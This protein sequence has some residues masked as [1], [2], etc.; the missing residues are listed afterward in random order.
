MTAP[1]ANDSNKNKINSKQN[2]ETIFIY[3]GNLNVIFEHIDIEEQ[4]ID[5]ARKLKEELTPRDAAVKVREK[6][7]TIKDVCKKNDDE[8]ITPLI[9]YISVDESIITKN[10][11]SEGYLDKV[12]YAHFHVEDEAAVE[13]LIPFYK[14]RKKGLPF[15]IASTP[16]AYGKDNLKCYSPI[17]VTIFRNG[18]FSIII[19]CGTRIVGLT[20]E[21]GGLIN[22]YEYLNSIQ[23]PEYL[24]TTSEIIYRLQNGE[25]HSDRKKFEDFLMREYSSSLKK[26]NIK[27]ECFIDNC[28]QL[29]C[30]DSQCFTPKYFMNFVHTAVISGLMPKLTTFFNELRLYGDP[31]LSSNAPLNDKRYFEQNRNFIFPADPDNF[32]EYK[33]NKQNYIEVNLHRPYIGTYTQIKKPLSDKKNTDWI[34]FAVAAAKT[35]PEYLDHKICPENHIKEQILKSNIFYPRDDFAHFSRRGFAIIKFIEDSIAEND[36][37]N[38]IFRTAVVETILVV[39]ETTLAA[40]VAA[41]KFEE[42]LDQV[43]HNFIKKTNENISNAS[44]SWRTLTK[45]DPLDVLNF[46]NQLNQLRRFLSINE[47]IINIKPNL[48]THSSVQVAIQIE[49]FNH[50]N[51]VISSAKQS[52]ESYTSLLSTS[53]QFWQ[54]SSVRL[55]KWSI[56]AAVA[57][58]GINIFVTIGMTLLEKNDDSCMFC[59]FG[60]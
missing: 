56:L 27:P 12:I 8:S 48:K 46:S 37:K 23:K 31:L 54:A 28:Q 53:N 52:L 42:I 22:K 3:T 44:N 10:Y 43:G 17:E 6:I 60:L 32:K 24:I 35:M 16:F 9:K 47:T 38:L 25:E 55:V 21:K 58:A 50:Y 11:F 19:R 57:L 51:E 29:N 36:S 59:L 49:N 14:N 34:R 7:L 40:G 18:T 1:D 15:S 13:E 26:D 33:Q 5:K 30:T 4:Y 39:I 2:I 20:D 45:K 41:K